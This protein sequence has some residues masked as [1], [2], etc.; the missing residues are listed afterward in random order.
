MKIFPISFLVLAALCA[1]A[2]LPMP[3]SRAKG[4]VRLAGSLL[5]G[6]GFIL[7]GILQGFALRRIWLLILGGVIL[8][9]VG[10][11]KYRR[12]PGG[13]TPSATIL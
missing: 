1:I 6:T 10:L 2:A 8:I 11:R 7:I 3:I 9:W 12:D 13:S 4:R 5:L